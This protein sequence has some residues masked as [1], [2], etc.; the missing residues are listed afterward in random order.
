MEAPERQDSEE[1]S[2]QS[3]RELQ[4]P[5]ATAA[6]APHS[7]PTPRAQEPQ[8]VSTGEEGDDV[9]RISSV[10]DAVLGEIISLLPT[11]DAARTQS[12]ASRWRHLWLSAPL[13][14]DHTSLPADEQVQ[15]DPRC[16]PRPRPPLLRASV[17]PPRPRSNGRSLAPILDSRQTPRARVRSWSNT[18]LL[19]TV[20]G[21]H[22]PILG[23][24]T[25]GH[26]LQI[27]SG[28]HGRNASLS[29]AQAAWTLNFSKSRTV[30]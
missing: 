13:N 20:A 23:H 12:L 6:D 16:S 17:P 26:L 21:L 27:R 8:P 11:R 5:P 29:P 18:L 3:P 30:Q 10:P 7:E 2:S 9:D 15:V 25:C 22:L 1:K 4:P 19:S 24:P 28:G 14:L